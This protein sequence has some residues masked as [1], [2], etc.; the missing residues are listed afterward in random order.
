M[1]ETNRFMRPVIL[2]TCLTVATFAVAGCSSTPKKQVTT[3]A[4]GEKATIGSLVY[5]VVDTEI[6]TRLGD[7][8]ISARTPQNRF[9]LV[10]VSISNSGSD[11]TPIPSMTLVDDSGQSYPEL[12][13]GTKVPGWLGVVRK[14]SAAQTEQGNVVF[15]APAKH[16]RL[17]LTDELDEKEISVDVPLNFLHEQIGDVPAAT[18]GQPEIPPKR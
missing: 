9:V 12:A 11:D 10:R 6:F 7:D 3:Y 15:D 8:P 5:S 13:D 16:Y 4:A 2:F 1:C 17:R 18:G 14:V